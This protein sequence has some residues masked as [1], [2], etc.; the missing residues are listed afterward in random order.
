MAYGKVDLVKLKSFREVFY[1]LIGINA[2]NIEQ[3]KRL[4][5]QL[6]EFKKTLDM[7]IYETQNP[8]LIKYKGATSLK[9]FIAIFKKYYFIEY[10]R[11]YTLVSD[12]KEC[13]R[14]KDVVEK[15]EL[16]KSCVE[17]YLKWFW[18]IFK[19]D[20]SWIDDPVNISTVISATIVDKYLFHLD[21]EKREKKGELEESIINDLLSRLRTNFRTV[22]EN[23]NSFIKQHGKE[24]CEEL[25]KKSPL[26]EKHYKEGILKSGELR[27]FV[28]EW[29]KIIEEFRKTKKE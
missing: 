6:T 4:E 24:K 2:Y 3:D 25:N 11:E 20:N 18:E 13:K 9:T 26:F 17:L 5:K 14:I 22:K 29:E 16:N 7:C 15:I 19:P 21:M 28:E 8:E 23:I 12:A 27:T 1:N 10:S